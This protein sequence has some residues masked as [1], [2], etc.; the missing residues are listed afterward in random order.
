MTLRKK[1]ISKQIKKAI[2]EK[3]DYA[4]IMGETEAKKNT[5]V[6]RKMSD[7]SQT[8]VHIKDIGK[9]VKKLIK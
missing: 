4:V 3:A 9:Y 2:D 8:E 1:K 7:F 6:V 5:V